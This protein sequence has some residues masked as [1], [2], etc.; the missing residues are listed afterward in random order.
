[1]SYQSEKNTEHVGSKYLCKLFNIDNYSTSGNRKLFQNKIPDGWILKNDNLLIIEYKQYSKDKQSG[2]EQL[3]NYCNLV[4]Q[5]NNL[6]IY[7][8]LGIGTE[9]QNFEKYFYKF[10]DNLQIIQECEIK[11]IF[12]NVKQTIDPQRIHNM[13]V[14]N[15]KFEKAEELHD[16]LLI[17]VSSIIN[18]DFKEY[19]E[20]K[21]DFID[22]DFID[23][24]INHVE[25]QIS[26][27]V[28]NYKHIIESI[29][30][31][32]FKNSY[33]I[34]K[35]IYDQ[36]K[37]DP[38]FIS[39]LF[40]QFKKYNKYIGSNNEIWTPPVIAHFMF[41]I[42]TKYFKELDK[43]NV[44]D[45]CL[46]F[47]QLI[48]P[49][50]K[51]CNE[52]DIKLIVKGCELS[53]RAYFMGKIDLLN[54]NIINLHTYHEDFMNIDPIKIQSDISVNNP[55]YT[56][57]I[58]NQYDCL[59]FVIKS[60]DC[61]KI[62]I[63]IFPKARLIKNVKLNQKFLRNYKL[64]EVIELGDN[65]FKKVSTGNI[66]IVVATKLTKN[67]IDL[68][69]K[70]YDLREFSKEYK[71]IPHKNENVLTEKGKQILIDYL[72]NQTKYVEYEP[73]SENMIPKQDINLIHIKDNLIE[74]YEKCLLYLNSLILLDDESK[75]MFR[76]RIQT[77][78]LNIQNSESIIDLMKILYKYNF[79]HTVKIKL[80]D[81]FNLVKKTKNY[82]YKTTDKNSGDIPLFACKKLNNGIARYVKDEEYEGDIIAVIHHRDATCGYSFHYNGKLAW[83]TS[84]FII[85]PKEELRSKINLDY[86]A[87][88]L[89]L[90]IS[91]NHTQD[92]S[93]TKDQLMNF[94]IEYPK[95][96][97]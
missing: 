83:N 25:T 59:D 95:I 42:S 97:L 74:Q 78:I 21:I 60:C 40:Q 56:M 66:V 26:D 35:L 37:L 4:K 6:N 47:N 77:S 19:Y 79:V 18:E 68:K 63:N 92:E 55:P 11:K 30:K 75:N 44:L 96:L 12:I 5:T 41:R 9:S 81:Y 87:D 27:S 45:P 69:T 33:E 54:R 39:K 51:Y 64:L 57:N 23:R 93:F 49:F 86:I 67:N 88:Y 85:E 20:K 76:N 15:Y 73:T 70:Y 32:K 65:I 52:N 31:S 80:S 2:Y 89:T 38:N 53:S 24:L 17:I 34:C 58:S 3:L 94:K 36:Y 28:N 16:I 48:H 8:F 13:I 10:I 7:C 71:S 61:A 22:K 82:K 62:S 91:P 72:N 50:I 14:N 46:G 29:K 90:T 43:L 84:V 1:M